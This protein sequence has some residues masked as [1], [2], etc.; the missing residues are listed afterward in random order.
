MIKRLSVAAVALT[1]TLAGC[2][3]LRDAMSAHSNVAAKAA[4][5]EL[6]VAQLASL[7][8][9]SQAPLRKDIAQAVADAWVDYHLAGKAAANN[10][11][12]NDPKLIDKAM[13][14]V[15]DNVKARK[16]IEGV[17]KSWRVP[18][19]TDAEG[20]YNNGRVLAASHILLLTQGLPDSAKATARKKMDAIRAQVTTANFGDL[21]SKNSQ[22]PGS[23]GKGGSLGTFARG[24]MVPPFE[25]GLLALKPGEI[26]PVVETQYGY[27]IIR[28]PLYS[29]V[30]PDV[31]QASR[32]LGQQVAESTYFATLE[33]TSD[34]QMKSGI[35][36]TVRAV[37][38][39]PEAHRT[40]KTVLATSDIGEFRASDLARWMTTIPPQAGIQQRVKSAPDS[41]MPIFVKNFVRNEL[42]VHA[43]DS[44]KLGPDS[45]ELA[46]IRDMFRKSLTGAWTGLGIDPKNL[47]SAAKT[48]GDREKLARQRTE[49]YVKNL[50]AQKAQYVDVTE[51]VESALREKY[52]YDING[53]ALGRALIDA[54]Q[55]RLK[56]DSAKA[57]GQPPT[58]VPLPNQDTTK[59]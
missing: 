55:I 18:D 56:A 51:P 19:S 34:L 57:A 23:K 43:A 21:A 38:D 36:A 25:Q 2:D 26:S 12:L 41:L 9:S 32:G 24:A 54:S 59:R 53:E 33:R 37:V 49:E 46:Q 39:D 48:K 14:A 16:Y 28:R 44:A 22:D 20:F 7:M 47:S 15:I 42:V 30:K 35:V 31:V 13:W 17:S 29:E 52:G 50:M 3:S 6:S 11:S 58:A 27:H 45:T 4:G 40:D 1:V 8:G 5:A 10:D